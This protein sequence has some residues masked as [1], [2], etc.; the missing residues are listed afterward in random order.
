MLIVDLLLP[1]TVSFANAQPYPLLDGGA[2]EQDPVALGV[3]LGRE[4][5][6]R[7]DTQVAGAAAA[8]LVHAVAV[9]LAR[10]RVDCRIIR[11]AVALVEIAVAVTVGRDLAVRR[12]VVG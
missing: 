4:A 2:G 1:V 6:G 8:V 7:H 10:A 3:A 5:C 12:G 11:R 9:D